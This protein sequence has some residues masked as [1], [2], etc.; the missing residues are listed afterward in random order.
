MICAVAHIYSW[1]CSVIQ[2]LAQSCSFA[3]ACA[4]SLSLSFCSSPTGLSF[5]ECMH[6]NSSYRCKYPL[7]HYDYCTKTLHSY[8]VYIKSENPH[9]RTHC[10]PQYIRW[11]QS[12]SVTHL[13]L[14]M[15]NRLL[16]HWTTCSALILRKY[17]DRL[18]KSDKH[19]SA[20]EPYVSI[21]FILALLLVF[22]FSFGFV[23]FFL[24]RV[25]WFRC[26]HFT[27]RNLIYAKFSCTFL[28]SVSIWNM[29][30][31]NERAPQQQ[32]QQQ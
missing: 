2:S 25:Y 32:Q 30:N 16:L 20:R 31:S 7:N 21:P 26:M 11:I 29:K 14:Y 17:W 4:R 6:I 15:L 19:V 12:S 23:F 24:S 9:A 10:P 5:S 27:V 13:Y 28:F 8:H 3:F 22:F 18:I 1:Q